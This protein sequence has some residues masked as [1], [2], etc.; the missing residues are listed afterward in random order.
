MKYKKAYFTLKV[1]K[2][3][4]CLI[5][6]GVKKTLFKNYNLLIYESYYKESRRNKK[7][8][9]E[10]RKGERRKGHPYGGLKKL[11]NKKVFSKSSYIGG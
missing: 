7:R 8:K 5:C 10:K 1:L 6:K 3:L 4:G 11:I 9:G 2:G